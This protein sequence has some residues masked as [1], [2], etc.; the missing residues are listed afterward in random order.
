MDLMHA[1]A[2]TNPKQFV[3]H[4]KDLCFCTTCTTFYVGRA[5]TH[6]CLVPLPHGSPILTRLDL[7]EVLQKYEKAESTLNDQKILRGYRC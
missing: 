2:I 7:N 1:S 6:N 3:K 5:K 4:F